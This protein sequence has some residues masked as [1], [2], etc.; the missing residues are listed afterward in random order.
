MFFHEVILHKCTRFSLRGIETLTIK[1]G[2]KT[3]MVLG[4]NGAG[5][6]SLLKVGFTVLPAQQSDFEK[7]VGAFKSIRLSHN[8]RLYEIKTVFEK[9]SPEHVF[10]CDGEDLNVGRT[11][12]VQ[13][14][15][16]REHFSM[17]Q[18]IHDVLTGEERFTD[19]SPMRRREW[20]TKLSDT[21]FSYVLGLHARIKKGR[22]EAS[23]VV[24]RNNNRLVTESTKLM[25]E[26]DLIAL[27]NRSRELRAD[28]D[29][30]LQE[31][32]GN[33]RDEQAVK[34]TLF[35]QYRNL[36]QQIKNVLK[37]IDLTP[38][39]WCWIESMGHL[40]SM[41]DHRRGEIN[42]MER[43]LTEL[44]GV[45]QGL[46]SQMQTLKK[47][48]GMDEAY[49]RKE[50]S[51]LEAEVEEHLRHMHTGRSPE[52][53]TS[54]PSA[55]DSINQFR[56]MVYDL[57][58]DLVDKYPDHLVN[59]K[60]QYWDRLCSTVNALNSQMSNVQ[61]RLQHIETCD[62]SGCPKCGHVFK[63][64][65]EEGEYNRLKALAQQNAAK[66]LEVDALISE[67]RE[68]LDGANH[69]QQTIN[70]IQR[71]RQQHPELSDFWGYIDQSGGIQVG[72]ELIPAITMYTNDAIHA[73]AIRG[74]TETLAP[75]KESIN[76]IEKLSGE[77][78]TIREQYYRY[79]ARIQEVT[80]QIHR[81]H[82]EVNEL[83]VYQ[84]RQE[85]LDRE[86]SGIRMQLETIAQCQE[87]I[88]ETLRQN[89]LRDLVRGNQ[90][91]LA[92]VETTL[93][94]SEVQQG[95]VRDI[96]REIETMTLEEKAFKILEEALS[97]VDGLIAEQ[98]GI[99]LNSII[100]G[101]NAVIARIWGYNM[102]IKPC[103]ISEGDLDYRFP[104]YTVSSTNV[105]PD[106][107][108]GSTSQVDI[109]NQAFRLIVYKFLGLHG[110]PLYLDE[111][112]SSFDEVHRHNL[113][114][115]IKDLIDDTTYSQI[116]MISHYVDGQNSFPNSEIIV[117]DDSHISL[118]RT[119]NEHVSFT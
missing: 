82:Q 45:A 112:G 100:D 81:L 111:L 105:I 11:G 94:E 114:P 14:E 21:D 9:S 87:Q 80:D 39:D 89:D 104:L 55:L 63:Q 78:T 17:T 7:G 4:S 22:N 49:I 35:L 23:A 117:L 75:L 109:V 50:I 67:T 68:F 13:K 41:I 76:T 115:A 74:L 1:P 30:L 5:K 61:G 73:H 113:V 52:Q 99:Y 57:S 10:I 15:L 32:S 88:I 36:E 48:E 25:D 38:P 18:E 20:I 110:Y 19:M 12:A 37:K 65:I 53:M 44:S 90:V 47:I 116:F 107:S 93:T 95:I 8:G 3:Q 2:L 96:R 33:T 101:M 31:C 40:E 27:N 79:A 108:K 6:S 56:R 98:I 43:M 118:T 84:E 72:R 83:T 34:E 64:G 97:P 91:S 29:I 102:A 70:G 24:K 71:F 69:Y 66:M 86:V 54:H 92:M 26:N 106:V 60:R 51:N 16:V 85:R 46:E 59:E 58:S 62:A 119:Y 28:L 77:G 42:G 103:D